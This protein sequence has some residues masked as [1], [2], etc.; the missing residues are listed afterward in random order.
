MRDETL[1]A[2]GMLLRADDSVDDAKLKEVL[3]ACR[4]KQRQHR[5]LITVGKAA[6]LL[7]CHPMTVKRYAKKG[8][9]S[10]IRFSAR[11]VRY[12]LEEIEAFA[13]DGLDANREEEE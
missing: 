8:L 5:K 12:D 13:R 6:E 3:S 2:I 1:A 10:P 11:K 9:L 4:R 7:G